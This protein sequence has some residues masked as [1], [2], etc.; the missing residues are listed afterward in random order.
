L[1]IT[2]S[3]GGF[4]DDV[5]GNFR[6]HDADIYLIKVDANGN[7]ILEQTYGEDQHDFGQVIVATEDS[8]YFIFGSSQSNSHGSFDMILIKTDENYNKEWQAHYGGS[9]YE[10]GLSMDKNDQNDLFLFGTTKSYGLNGSADFY[11]IKTNNLGK[12]IWSL[13]IGGYDTE[14]GHQVISTPD[15]GCVV[16]GKTCSFGEGG[17]DFLF[18]KISKNGFI[19]YFINGFDSIYDS[20]PLVYPNPLRESG[21]IKLDVNLQQENYH[22]EIISLAGILKHSVTINPPDYY[23]Q[24]SNL[25]SGLYFYRIISK[26]TSEVLFSGKLVVH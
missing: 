6:N 5:H 7:K 26:K 9:G 13:T 20:E 14:F 19:E 10:Y 4:F 23:F 22:M 1:L 2:G 3:K 18:T 24:T 21:R 8:G 16:I 12:E 25:P 17:Y 11:L 15:S